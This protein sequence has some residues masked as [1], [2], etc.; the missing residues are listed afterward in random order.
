MYACMPTVRSTLTAPMINLVDSPLLSLE[1]SISANV[2]VSEEVICLQALQAPQ[3][4][5]VPKQMRE[6][7]LLSP[8]S[9]SQGLSSRVPVS[10]TPRHEIELVTGE[11]SQTSAA[12]RAVCTSDAGD[13]GAALP[14][15]YTILITIHAAHRESIELSGGCLAK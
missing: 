7:A 14:S 6:R 11:K 5:M 1:S 15:R 3:N 12:W 10:S 4:S 13:R 2:F 8:L 9:G